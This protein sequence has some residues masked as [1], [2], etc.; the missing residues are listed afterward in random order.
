IIG[1]SVA[2]IV[3]KYSRIITFEPN[4]LEFRFYN[5]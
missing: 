1:S 3:G 5:L 2:R 4:R